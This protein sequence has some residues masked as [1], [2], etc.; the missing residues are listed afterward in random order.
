MLISLS[1]HLFIF[2]ELTEPVVSLF[3]RHGF[4]HAE[5]WAMPPHF[6]YR[7]PAEA[8]RIA[9]LFRDGGVS[10]ASLHA[11][12]YPDVRSYRKDRWYSLC[13]RDDAHRKASVDATAEAGR[14][15]AQNGG[16][17]L[18]L[19]TSFPAD[20]WYP[21]RWAA[22]LSS[23]SELSELVPGNVRFAVENTPLPSGAT[24]VVLDIV[25]RFP[26]E[27]VGVCLDLGHANIQENATNALRAAADRLVHIHAH[28]NH[29]AQD[30]HLVPGK[31]S[32]RWDDVFA[33]LREIRFEGAFTVELSDPARGEEPL[34]GG[35][36]AMLAQCRAALDRFR[37]SLP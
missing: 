15:L 33:A 26:R 13:S 37:G 34:D 11:P 7:D 35:V 19:H 6:P 21:H 9:G 22:F 14:W 32:I 1:T 36:E 25:H 29:G 30:D 31:G 10:V 2:R 23:V 8:A 20:A 5:L 12:I 3:R 18:V 4:A 16:G 28:D 27:R 17:T 24:D